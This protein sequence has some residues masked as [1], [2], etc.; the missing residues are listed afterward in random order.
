MAAETPDYD[1][2]KEAPGRK[3]YNRHVLTGSVC[4]NLLNQLFLSASNIEIIQNAI[5]YKVWERSGG[6]LVISKQDETELVITMRSIYLQYGRN[7]PSDVKG[8]IAELNAKVIEEVV[9]GIISEAYG[10]EQYLIDAFT[11]PTPIPRPSN[12]SS[13]GT[14]TLRSVTSVF[15]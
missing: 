15:A 10:Y 1:T 2:F 4:G 14:K 5:R 13:S 3:T 8:Q 6:K 7:T 11:Q 12:V 9:P